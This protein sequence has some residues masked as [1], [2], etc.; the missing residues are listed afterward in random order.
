MPQYFI[1][2]GVY[3][4][5]ITDVPLQSRP[6]GSVAVPQRPSPEDVWTGSAWQYVAPPLPPITIPDLSFAQMLIGLDQ[7]G[8][9]PRNDLVAWRD[10]AVLPP[11]V[12]S[13]ILSLPVEARFTAETRAL[14]PSVIKIDNPILQ[15]IAASAGKTDADLE[16]F[17]IEFSQV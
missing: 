15:L 12:V 17:F 5:T 3:I 11:L 9:V 7:R 8:W 2:N 6:K 4:E 1:E 10:S 14:R 16:A 13:V